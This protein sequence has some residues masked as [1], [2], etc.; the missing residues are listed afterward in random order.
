[1]WSIGGRVLTGEDSSTGREQSRFC[2]DFTRTSL[3]D[4]QHAW[5]FNGR[6][7]RALLLWDVT[8]HGRFPFLVPGVSK[9]VRF[10]D[11]V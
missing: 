2:T 6:V 4:R 1:M 9:F 5:E 10:S 11:I 7:Q 8:E 3:L